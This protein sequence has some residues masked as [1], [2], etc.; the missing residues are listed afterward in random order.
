GGR[1]VG[2]GILCCCNLPGAV[3]RFREVKSPVRLI[4][5]FLLS[6]AAVAVL[7]AGAVTAVRWATYE[8]AA[9]AS[10]GATVAQLVRTAARPVLLPAVVT[11]AL[12]CLFGILADSGRKTVRLLV[13]FVLCG[14]MI[15]GGMRLVERLE[16][17][18]EPGGETVLRLQ[19]RL[20]YRAEGID[21]YALETDGA[22]MGP[23]VV[24]EPGRDPAFRV[25]SEMRLDPASGRLLIPES[26]AVAE[27]R[28]DARNVENAYWR[29]FRPPAGFE[30]LFRDVERAGNAFREVA[31]PG[32]ADFALLGWATALFIVSLWPLIRLTRWPL[33][34]IVLAVGAARGLFFLFTVTQNEMVREGAASLLGRNL[35]YVLPGALLAI[36]TVLLLVLLVLRPYGEWKR[37]VGRA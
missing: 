13:L 30:P 18:A 29:A 21:F 23:A 31:P 3:L 32:G 5:R 15:S 9:S 10:H 7:L 25:V 34:N 17:S 26:E 33:L 22:E 28:I 19:P 36:S 8:T 12:V 6:F 37:E 27:R 1:A 16:A 2:R 35:D 11:A 24:H 4:A 20:L 14:V